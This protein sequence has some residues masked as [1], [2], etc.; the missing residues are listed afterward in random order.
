M[1][2]PEGQDPKL[3]LYQQGLL[4]PEVK[5]LLATLGRC[6]PPGSRVLDLGGYIGAFGLGAAA[7]GYDVVIVEAN[8]QNAAFI[9]ASIASNT[10]ARPVRLVSA[11]IGAKRG[12]VRFVSNGPW[13]HVATATDADTVSVPQY[14]LPDLLSQVG[15][16]APD[17]IKMDI[18]GS[19][20]LMLAGAAA[21]FA[22]GHRPTLLYEANAVT[23]AWFDASPRQ[24]NHQIDALGYHRYEM[25]DDGQLRSLARFEPRCLVDYVASP[26]P[27]AAAAPHSLWKTCKRTGRALMHPAPEARR[28]TRAHLWDTLTG[29]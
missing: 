23:L 13:G 18:E 5:A 28:Y 2:V 24:L 4:P 21:W 10:F 17:F 6:V 12:A 19:E 1:S 20:A 8:P 14:P 27:L 15:W 9:E 16:T 11:A 26:V 3:A 7:L 29:R 25:D 22:E